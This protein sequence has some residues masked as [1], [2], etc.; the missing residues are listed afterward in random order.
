MNDGG[1]YMKRKATLATIAIATVMWFIVSSVIGF[2]AVERLFGSEFMETLPETF[3]IFLIW[4]W[5]VT[6]HPVVILMLLFIWAGFIAFAV[7]RLM[8][9]FARKLRWLRKQRR[10]GIIK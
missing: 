8:V 1:W 4:W 3:N 9:D 2:L 7:N 5:M 10:V 6:T